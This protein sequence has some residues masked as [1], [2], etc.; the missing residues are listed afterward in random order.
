[1]AAWKA[2]ELEPITVHQCRHTCASFLIAPATTRRRCRSCSGHAS[3]SIKFDRYGHR[4]PGGGEAEVGRLLDG[5][6]NGA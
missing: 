1:M 5:Y 6:I 3:I 4:M 2:A